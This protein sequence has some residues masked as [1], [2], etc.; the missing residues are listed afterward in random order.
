MK[1]PS[2]KGI[3]WNYLALAFAVPVLCF[4]FLMLVAGYAPFGKYSMLY[5]DCYHQYF[6]FFKAFRNALRSGQSLLWS[7]DVGM[8]LD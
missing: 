2:V 1:L 7:W 4:L 8:G 5:S 3:K 6:P